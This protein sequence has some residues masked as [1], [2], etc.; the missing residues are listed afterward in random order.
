[1]NVAA[2]KFKVRDDYLAFRMTHQEQAQHQR[3][4]VPELDPI[5]PRLN[6]GV[7]I[8]REVR[9]IAE[10][11]PKDRRNEQVID[12]CGNF[13]VSL[14]MI[15]AAGFLKRPEHRALAVAY[16]KRV[17]PLWG[18]RVEKFGQLP[19]SFVFNALQGIEQCFIGSNTRERG[20]SRTSS[21][22]KRYPLFVGF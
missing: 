21:S 8:E 13:L 5:Y 20:M 10:H 7:R 17:V 15:E 11:A 16:R 9:R 3:I 4:K 2:I 22:I 6:D 1:V 12:Q 14:H 18:D 19:C